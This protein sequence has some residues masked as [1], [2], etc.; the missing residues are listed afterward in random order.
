VFCESTETWP[1]CEA[2]RSLRSSRHPD[3]CRSSLEGHLLA[4]Q[5]GVSIDLARMNK[6]VSLHPKD[7]RHVQAGV[8]R[9]QLNTEI[10]TPDSSFPIDRARTRASA[11]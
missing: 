5:G 2:S 11:A 1:T 9:N 8:T 3:R 10:A 7:L 4:V 6:I